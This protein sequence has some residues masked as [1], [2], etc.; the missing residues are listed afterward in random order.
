M[1]IRLDLHVHSESRGET[2]I[3]LEQLRESL[4][5]GRLDGVAI[6]NFFDISHAVWLRKK[7]EGFIIIV[8]QEI[9]TKEGH[10]IGLGLEKRIPDFKSAEETINNIREQGGI[11]V[12]PHPYLFLGL[13]KRVMSLPVDAIESYNGLIGASVIPNY[14]AMVSARRRNIPQ[15]ASTDTTYATFIG[16]SH[17]EVMV[18]D[19]GLILSAIRSGEVRLC[20]KALPI[21]IIFILKNLLNFRNIEPCLLHAVPCFIC[22]R[23]IAVRIFKERLKCFDCGIVQRSRIFCSNGHF[24]CKECLIKRSVAVQSWQ[25]DS[26]VKL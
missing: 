12:A 10:I 16:R 17:T 25:E 4:K 15:I 6:T 23:S 8:G 7:L 9:W 13:G 14:L 22:G 21:P 24:I 11:S 26:S 18:E 5:Q 3:G 1:S 19:R 2:Y 20:K